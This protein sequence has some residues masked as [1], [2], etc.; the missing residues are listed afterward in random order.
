MNPRRAILT[1]AICLLT[2]AQAA[3]RG[4]GAAEIPGGKGYSGPCSESGVVVSASPEAT[5]VGVSILEKGG[6]AVDAAVAVGF[7][8]AVTYPRAGNIG[9]GGFML[10]REP[11]EKAVFIDFRE[12]APNAAFEKMYL[13][14]KG[15]VIEGASTLGHSACGVP[16]SVAGLWKVYSLYGTLSWKELLEP[17]VKLAGEGF[18]LSGQMAE[19]L[20]DLLEYADEYPGLAK[21][22]SEKGKPLAR[23]E[24]LV[25]PLLAETL[26]RVAEYGRDGFYEGKTARLIAEEMKRGEGLI[27]VD[28]LREYRAVVRKP[29]EGDYR[30]YHIIS[31]PPPSSGGTVLLEILNILE[32]YDLGKMGFMSVDAVHLMVEAEK[33]AYHDRA[34]YMGDSDFVKV[35]LGRL[36]S[37]KYASRLRSSISFFASGAGDIGKPVPQLEKEETT[38]YSI[39]DRFGM[40]VSTTTTL[41]GSY[42]SKVV[43]GGA[44]FL[45]NNEMD[46]FSIKPGY[47]NMYGLVG[48]EANAIEPGKRMLSSMTPTIITRNG[49]VK[50]IL[51][52]PGGSTI[53]TS[54]A[55]ILIDIIDFKLAP[56]DAVAASRY[57][58]QYLPDVVFHESGAFSAELMKGLVKRGHSLRARSA[59]G[60]V[61]LIFTSGLSACG[62]SDP[63]NEGLAAGAAGAE[64]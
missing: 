24:K 61:Q 58:H 62:F 5:R 40:A 16:G 23:G 38:H 31:A 15:E 57:H 30:G 54:V 9:G 13:D 53:I 27:S 14:E 60:D 49:K 4:G 59:I 42:G 10:V 3:G 11:E 2:L 50:M 18:I 56:R 47:P 22:S 19:S 45:L 12:T 43:V 37:K 25:Q 6:N 39:I 35:P 20:E 51:G 8:L 46:D 34:L 21:F 44:G 63:R 32:G 26:N 17:A 64:N 55:Q 28:D 29:L 1:A 33:R 48:G 41:N 52:T 36:I 7:V